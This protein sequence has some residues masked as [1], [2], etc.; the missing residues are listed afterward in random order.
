MPWRTDWAAGYVPHH[1]RSVFDRTI[2]NLVLDGHSVGYVAFKLDQQV[3]RTGGHLW[4]TKRSAPV[5]VVLWLEVLMPG[6][7]DEVMQDG[8]TEVG[9]LADWVARA[10]WPVNPRWL[11]GMGERRDVDAVPTLRFLAGSEKDHAWQQFGWGDD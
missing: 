4:W 10:A 3:T 6:T 7:P 11:R 8:I 5:D 2:A 9:R 1:D